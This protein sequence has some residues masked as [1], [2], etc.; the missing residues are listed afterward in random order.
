[1]ANFFMMIYSAVP[2]ALTNNVQQSQ[3]Q[4]TEAFQEPVELLLA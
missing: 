1:M 2:I 4:E 3:S